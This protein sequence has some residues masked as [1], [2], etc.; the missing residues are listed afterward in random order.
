VARAA[1]RQFR[2]KAWLA[3][4]P[5][6]SAPTGSTTSSL[7]AD[8]EHHHRSRRL[9]ADIDQVNIGGGRSNNVEKHAEVGCVAAA[10]RRPLWSSVAALKKRPL[11][12]R[13]LAASR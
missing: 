3:A 11:A 10:V 5:P 9:L 7:P 4:L 13:A 8:P 1:A 2:G 6:A 12:Q